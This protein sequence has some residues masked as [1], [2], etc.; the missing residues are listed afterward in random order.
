MGV[1]TTFLAEWLPRDVVGSMLV[2]NPPAPFIFLEKLH[3]M[4]L[5]LNTV[6]VR[7][8]QLLSHPNILG[9][10]PS[11]DDKLR[12]FIAVQSRHDLVRNVATPALLLVPACT[13]FPTGIAHVG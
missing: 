10:I 8:F 7:P 5:A 9:C 2:Q 13:A 12:A 6:G 1:V 4:A 11:Y 3:A